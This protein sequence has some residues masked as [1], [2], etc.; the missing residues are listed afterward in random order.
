MCGLS[1]VGRMRP[2]Q[3][4]QA[5]ENDQKQVDASVLGWREVK[6]EKL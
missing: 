1:D 3:A 4:R 6:E 2:S 5:Q